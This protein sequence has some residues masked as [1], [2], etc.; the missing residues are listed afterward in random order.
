MLV[1][2]SHQGNA[3]QKQQTVCGAGEKLDP[4]KTALENLKRCGR[5]ENSLAVP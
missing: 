1:I 3:N 2:M 4:Q 5:P